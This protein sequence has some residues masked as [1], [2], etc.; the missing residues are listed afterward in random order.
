MDIS[1]TPE[2]I[3]AAASSTLGILSL[4]CLILG[5]IALAFF[6]DAPVNAKIVVFILLLL[7]SCGFGYSIIKQQTPNFTP[8]VTRES[9]LG[10]WESKQKMGDHEGISNTTFFKDGSF[11]GKY[12]SFEKETG[13]RIPVKGTWKFTELTSDKFRLTLKY[14]DGHQWQSEVRVKGSNIIHIVDD[15]YLIHRV[16]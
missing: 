7:S 4:M 2:L 6:K 10:S 8:E 11:S 16:E 14:D 12:T 5:I 1:I 15:N 3:K 9:L 13:H